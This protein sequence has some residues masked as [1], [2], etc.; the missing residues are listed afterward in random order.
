MV[1]RQ[2][3]I[4]ILLGAVCLAAAPWVQAQ[5]LD[6]RPGL[7]EHSI[8]ITGQSAEMDAAMRE[9]KAQLESM[10]PEQRAM[11]ERM[12][13][14]QGISFDDSG[15]TM[16]SIKVCLTEDDIAQGELP[17]QDECEQEILER[18]AERLRVRF[19]CQDPPARGEGEV[20]FHSPTH[21]TSTATMTS[22]ASGSEQTLV[23]EQTGEWLSED[24]AGH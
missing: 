15:A 13:A 21:Y 6:L 5:T 12:M 22:P 14:D 1:K 23:M 11:M 24:C 17:Q 10:P 2:Q 19:E 18:S 8:T 3:L 7:W 4:R 20:V 9:M 16:S